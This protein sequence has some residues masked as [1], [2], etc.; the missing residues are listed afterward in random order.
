MKKRIDV[1]GLNQP[2]ATG[3]KCT[4]HVTLAACYQLVQSV[5]KRVW[6]RKKGGIGGGVRA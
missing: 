4:H 1:K 6:A 5:L 2:I 3:N